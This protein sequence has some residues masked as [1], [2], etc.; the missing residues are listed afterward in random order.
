[1]VTIMLLPAMLV[2]GLV[3][4]AYYSFAL[5]IAVKKPVWNFFLLLFSFVTY[6]GMMVAV[7]AILLFLNTLSHGSVQETTNIALVVFFALMFVGTV[8][9]I[10]RA[11]F[12]SQFLNVDYPSVSIRFNF[13]NFIALLSLASE[14]FSLCAFVFVKSVPWTES[15]GLQIGMRW[16]L[17]DFGIKVDGF[18]VSFY[19]MLSCVCVF[20][21]AVTVILA[22]YKYVRMSLVEIGSYKLV[23][24]GFPIFAE[25]IFIPV[26]TVM[27]RAMNCSVDPSDATRMYLDASPTV[28]CWTG[29]H[30]FYVGFSLVALM[31]YFPTA[32]FMGTRLTA[33]SDGA[34]V[35]EKLDIKYKPIFYMWSTF[36]KCVLAGLSTFFS[37]HYLTPFLFV[38]LVGNIY[39]VLLNWYYQPCCVK[40]I[41]K[42][43]A[44]SYLAATW[45]T[46]SALVALK[47]NDTTSRVS[48]YVL[49]GGLGVI[50]L[51]IA[52]A[53]ATHKSRS[54]SVEVYTFGQGHHG[55]L[56]LGA[57]RNIH[58]PLRNGSLSEHTITKL[59]CFA[60]MNFAIT[61]KSRVFCWGHGPLLTIRCPPNG[62]LEPT[63][64]PALTGKRL[65]DIVVGNRI[66]VGI[67][68]SGQ[69]F[70]W[71]R[72]NSR[73]IDPHPHV[74]SSSSSSPKQGR[75]RSA[76][77]A[78]ADSIHEVLLA[79]EEPIPI[80]GEVSGLAIVK[81]VISPTDSVFMIAAD[82]RVAV[83]GINKERL[84]GPEVV[85]EVC[86][87]SV[88]LTLGLEGVRVVDLIVRERRALVIGHRGELLTW[89]LGSYGVLGHGHCA[90]LESPTP[91]EF[92]PQNN[93]VVLQASLNDFYGVALTNDGRVF[94]WGRYDPIDQTRNDFYAAR[95]LPS[96]AEETTDAWPTEVVSLRGLPVMRLIAD[97]PECL[98]VMLD[99]HSLYRIVYKTIVADP[100][101]A[102][103]LWETANDMASNTAQT[104]LAKA[105]TKN[106]RATAL[107]QLRKQ[108]AARLRGV[109]FTA[110]PYLVARRL[111]GGHGISAID[112]SP[113]MVAVSLTRQI[114]PR[115]SLVATYI[116]ILFFKKAP[117]DY[118]ALDILSYDEPIV[119]GK[120][121]HV[122]ASFVKSMQIGREHVCCL[123]VRNSFV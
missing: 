84:M 38:T 45:S 47:V 81:V 110:E 71:T 109:R 66:A 111:L 118:E 91:V 61:N 57:S 2:G 94:M 13:D 92:F 113:E 98:L 77:P 17:F 74:K 97:C 69:V 67:T 14:F 79:S 43:R 31:S 15:V 33:I 75:R 93:L 90:D 42:A 99:D 89:G 80:P 4:L 103:T 18:L 11:N 49:F 46:I 27:M 40:I 115:V 19:L 83:F 1:M 53:V 114:D 86:S 36:V 101:R 51:G 105:K 64:A 37:A 88:I 52:I 95:P 119:D 76:V 9:G 5:M 41:N 73:E 25:T 59:V 70:Y 68:E 100:Q 63:E 24:I 62:V 21:V 78:N 54:S 102:H 22:L 6:F 39:L 12:Q 82:G 117:L 72:S 108:N 10:T 32:L 60:K 16:F 34:F 29:K 30:R 123:A 116:K 120:E 26:V 50:V 58:H 48:M 20:F 55:E 35:G 3:S 28:Q 96:R 44:L 7:V 112:A 106:K 121:Y 122:P 104:Q 107:N 8:S 56:G 65:H 87:S 23:N 85:D